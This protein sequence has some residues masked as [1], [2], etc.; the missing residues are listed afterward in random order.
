MLRRMNETCSVAAYIEVFGRQVSNVLPCPKFGLLDNHSATYTNNIT[1]NVH[2]KD[3][4]K[5]H[6]L[7]RDGTSQGWGGAG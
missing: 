6:V 1:D 3:V 4:A 2:F 7:E 5:L